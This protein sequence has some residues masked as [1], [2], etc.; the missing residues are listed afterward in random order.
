MA[1]FSALFFRRAVENAGGDAH[2][3]RIVRH[4]LHHHRIG[5]DP[6]IV[7]DRDRT[8]DLGARPHHHARFQRGMAL[9]LVPRSA[10]QRDAVI[11][12]AIVADFGGLA[13]HHAHAVIDEH[14][15]AD[16]GAGVDFDAGQPARRY[17]K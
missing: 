1:I 16:G 10:A 11:E 7:A 3:R 12:R 17:A 9:A 5:A 2:R 6:R 14:A 8:Q 13:H 15:A 4:I